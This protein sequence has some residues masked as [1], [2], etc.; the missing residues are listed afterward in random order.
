[1]KLNH[2][3]GDYEGETIR[4]IPNGHGKISYKDGAKYEGE[5]VNGMRNG[6]GK[7]NHPGGEIYIGE[8]RNG[9]AFGFGKYYSIQKGSANTDCLSGHFE[10]GVSKGF[11]IEEMGDGSIQYSFSE[12]GIT[13]GLVVKISADKTTAQIFSVKDNEQVGDSIDLEKVKS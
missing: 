7:F 13:Q 3:D 9:E 8:F 2:N 10:D 1:M 6:S 4:G 5:W 12:K 11:I